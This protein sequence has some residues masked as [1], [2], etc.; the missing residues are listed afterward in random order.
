MRI[1]LYIILWSNGDMA[2][3]GWYGTKEKWNRIEEP[4]L[5]ANPIVLSFAREAGLKVTKNHK[6]W[7]ERS[8]EWGTD[9]HR[10]IQ[11][12]L[13]NETELTFNL[14]LCASQDRRGKRY[15]KSEFLIKEQRVPSFTESLEFLLQDGKKRLDSWMQSDLEF[16]TKLSKR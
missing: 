9:I 16:V 5:I 14:W 1:V 7:P 3:G 15:W 12:Y 6:S 13:A 2:N 4:L 11:L 8:M 10:L